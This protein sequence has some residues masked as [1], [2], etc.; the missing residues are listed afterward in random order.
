MGEGKTKQINIYPTTGDEQTQPAKNGEITKKRIKS[1][2]INRFSSIKFSIG[3]S[4]LTRADAQAASDCQF[5]YPD[6]M[7]QLRYGD[8]KCGDDAAG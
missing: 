1:Y 4:D 2:G 5:K 7:N 6:Y 3:N 8:K